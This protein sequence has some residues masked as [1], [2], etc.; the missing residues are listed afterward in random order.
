MNRRILGSLQTNICLHIT[1]YRILACYRIYITLEL[2]I[3]VGR[4]SIAKA[5][6]SAQELLKIS[7]MSATRKQIGQLN[8]LLLL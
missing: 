2:L 8:E 7:Q 5:K 6:A 1:S 3:G 4:S